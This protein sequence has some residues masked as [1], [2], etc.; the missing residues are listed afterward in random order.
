ME[1]IVI[2]RNHIVLLYYAFGHQ[3]VIAAAKNFLL[4]S[5]NVFYYPLYYILLYFV[6]IICYS[7]SVHKTYSYSAQDARSVA[8]S[9]LSK[10]NHTIH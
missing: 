5:F 8:D 9:E 7:I 4:K 6:V 3:S 10:C 1:T 2:T